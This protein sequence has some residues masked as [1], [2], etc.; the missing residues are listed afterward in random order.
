MSHKIADLV[1]RAMAIARVLKASRYG[2][3]NRNL[4]DLV[5]DEVREPVTERQIRE[6]LDQMESIGLVRRERVGKGSKALVMW[7]WDAPTCSDA[8]WEADARERL[9][10]L[11][12]QIDA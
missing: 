1:F 10:K 5:S 6:M 12:G 2:K 4:I 9:K 11:E 8:L 7:Y 3:S